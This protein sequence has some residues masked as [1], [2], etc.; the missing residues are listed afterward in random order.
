M[1]NFKDNLGDRDKGFSGKTYCD[2]SLY[3]RTAFRTTTA[4]TDET[5]AALKMCVEITD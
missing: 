2:F 4:V 5:Y 1:W 3:S